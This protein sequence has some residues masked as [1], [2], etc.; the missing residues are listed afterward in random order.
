[1]G[2]FYPV[3][4][5]ILN[6]KEK[7]YVMDCLDSTW[8]SSNGPY[9]RKFEEEFAHFCGTAHAVACCNGTT[10]L[11]LALLAH[12][13][14]P[15]DEIIMPTFTF[16]ATANA[17]AY[18]G[19]KPVFVDSEAETWN[20]DTCLIE[21]NITRCTKG[22]I[23][24]HLYGHPADMDPVRDIANQY[25]LFVVED[26]AE[27]LG[28]EYKGK[29]TGGL[30]HSAIFSLFGNKIITTG[31]GGML[32]TND[33]RIAA[34]ARVLRG[35]GMDLERRYWHPV[36][37]YNYRMT[38]IQA[39][40][41]YAQLQNADWHI[42]QRLRIAR[43]Y[44]EYLRRCG[45]I[46]LPAEKEWARNVFWLYSVV[47]NDMSERQRDDVIKRLYQEGIESRP[48]FYPMHVLPPYQ[49]LQSGS[50][51]PVAS[52]IC[53]QGINLPS[54]GTLTEED[55]KWISRMLIEV[56]DEVN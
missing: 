41:G 14:G 47:L 50:E 2:K 15:G 51:F 23:A 35:Q 9:I 28:A 49:H 39:A 45:S 3:A 37:G 7:E 24:V 8:I 34:K 1:M 16:V 52:R 19:A 25:G 43:H 55:I 17:V 38:N 13:V 29:R 53:A 42:K 33:A 48:F 6:G 4:L 12:G 56:I 21:R 32:T 44:D 30:G 18:C 36:I 10:A 27:A 40:I 11:H 26:A 5:P 31:E 46:T 54:Y 22:I 20:I